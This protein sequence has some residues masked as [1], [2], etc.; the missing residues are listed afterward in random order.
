L[1][2]TTVSDP[3]ERS[4]TLHDHTWYGHIV[5][6]HSEVRSLRDAVLQALS[7]PLEIRISAADANCRLFLSPPDDRGIMV[8][9]IADIASGYVKTS[10]LVK[11]A[12]GAIEWSRPTP[13]KES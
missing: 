6:R 9:V 11:K 13:S 2:N 1:P 4:I 7:D 5:K 3:L 10:H 8:V 12:K